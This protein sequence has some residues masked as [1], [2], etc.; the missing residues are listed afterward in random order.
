[1]VHALIGVLLL[2]G[3]WTQE[4][5]AN[6]AHGRLQQMTSGERNTLFAKFLQRSGQRCDSVTRNFFQ[7]A[8]KS[9]D[10]IW[11]ATCRDG[12]MFAVLI[13]NDAKGSSKILSCATLKAINAGD[14]Y[15]KVLRE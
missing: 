4:A 1:M 13:Y 9:G 10:A 5:S 6:P 15:K 12:Q 7:G 2:V 14:C 3:I 8:T 11:N